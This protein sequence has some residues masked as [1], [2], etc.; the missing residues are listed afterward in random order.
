MAPAERAPAE[1]PNQ[2]FKILLLEFSVGPKIF[3]TKKQT[4]KKYISAS[5]IY[6][7]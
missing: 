7:L 2:L 3:T 6:S 5:Y 1:M 4:F